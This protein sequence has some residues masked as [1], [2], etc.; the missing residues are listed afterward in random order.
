MLFSLLTDFAHPVFD[1]KVIAVLISTSLGSCS[2]YM[3]L[4]VL[5]CFVVDNAEVRSIQ[6]FDV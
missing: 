6:T 3:P 5:D 4:I 2:G 1:L